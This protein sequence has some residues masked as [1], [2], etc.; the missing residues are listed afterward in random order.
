MG[1]IKDAIHSAMGN[2]QVKNG[3]GGPQLPFRHRNDQIGVSPSLPG[4]TYSDTRSY[5]NRPY[6]ETAAR[7]QQSDDGEYYQPPPGLPPRR[8]QC[9][10]Y[11]QPGNDVEK[12]F[13]PLVLPQIE[14]GAGQPFLR[15]YSSTLQRFG[16]SDKQFLGVVDELNIAIVPSPENQI[17]QKG[18]SIAGWFL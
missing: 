12:S 3:F 14:F 6:C 13:R 4:T 10:R 16:I 11:Q 9:S 2:D 7:Y 5:I 8:Q 1:L 17:F 18:A 15:G